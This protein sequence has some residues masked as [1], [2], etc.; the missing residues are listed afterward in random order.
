L[1]L[2]LTTDYGRVQDDL[3]S[4]SLP[5]DPKLVD[6]NNAPQHKLDVDLNY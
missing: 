2:V 5:S 1:K 4:S 6:V 3:I